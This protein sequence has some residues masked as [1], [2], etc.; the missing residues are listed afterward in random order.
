MST[1]ATRRSL[2][3]A[4]ATLAGAT[5]A[6]TPALALACGNAMGRPDPVLSV[7]AIGLVVGFF[8]FVAMVL[9]VIASRIGKFSARKPALALCAV[10]FLGGLAWFAVEQTRP[11]TVKRYHISN[12]LRR[13][14][15][16]A[17]YYFTGDQ[18]YGPSEPWHKAGEQPGQEG[19]PV[20]FEQYTFPGGVNFSFS[21]A[22]GP[23]VAPSCA[24]APV[25]RSAFSSD[26]QDRYFDLQA[27]KD[28]HP[29][30]V[31]AFDKL[32]YDLSPRKDALLLLGYETGPGTGVK[33]TA[34]V[35]VLVNFKAE[36]P[37]CHTE[38]VF[39]TVDPTTKE[40]QVSQVLKEHEL[41]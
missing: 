22:K 13:V 2:R 17:K 32:N 7:F 31:A 12:T 3:H 41:E 36:T 25:L 14:Q 9:L 11:P 21:S 27:H 30:A 33:A 18:K 6:L 26:H 10:A 15:D 23:G 19:M 16:G 4:L 24:D 1:L 40:V 37:E 39:L 29:L 35:T 34:T 38:K 8:W 5:L 20:P 28:K